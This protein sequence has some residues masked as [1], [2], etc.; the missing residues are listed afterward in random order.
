MHIFSTKSNNKSSFVQRT[1][2]TYKI[3]FH[4]QK[5]CYHRY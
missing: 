5:Q 4:H 1:H 2:I 3:K